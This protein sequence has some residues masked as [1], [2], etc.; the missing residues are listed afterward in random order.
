MRN[1]G[2]SQMDNGF[3]RVTL[4]RKEYE[5]LVNKDTIAEH[6]GEYAIKILSAIV[7]NNVRNFNSTSVK[8]HV[9]TA[10]IYADALINELKENNY[11][12]KKKFVKNLEKLSTV[13]HED[14][15]ND[16]IFLKGANNGETE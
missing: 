13:S 2:R 12:D 15:V 14:A 8:F 7:T 16:Y 3:E 6:R 4:T 1:Y 9:S 11:W 5:E 10:L